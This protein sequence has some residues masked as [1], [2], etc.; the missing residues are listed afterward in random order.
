MSH[1]LSLSKLTGK[2]A[3][4]PAQPL[5]SFRYNPGDEDI[6]E[7]HSNGQKRVPSREASLERPSKAAEDKLDTT[8]ASTTRSHLEKHTA[9]ISREQASAESKR[10]SSDVVPAEAENSKVEA[11][12][13]KDY[14]S[15][16]G[17]KSASI[18]SAPPQAGIPV[19]N[20]VT[21]DSWFTGLRERLTKRIEGKIQNTKIRRDDESSSR[22]KEEDGRQASDDEK[23]S[24][25]ITPVDDCQEVVE[26]TIPMP[27]EATIVTYSRRHT[28]PRSESPLRTPQASLADEAGGLTGG[29]QDPELN[30]W[31]F[32]EQPERPRSLPAKSKES[33]GESSKAP[34]VPPPSPFVQ[35]KEY[36]QSN[37]ARVAMAFVVLA[38]AMPLP[39]FISGF[40]MGIVLSALGFSFAW[41]LLVPTEPKVPFVVPDYK[42]MPPLRVPK[43][44]SCVGDT[45]R[46]DTATYEG[47]MCQLPFS[48]EYNV[49]THHMNNTQSVNLVL[50][51]SILRLRWPKNGVPRRAMW[52][53][54]RPDPIFIDHRHYNISSAKLMLLP[55]K[56]S[57]QR[58]WNRKYPI[59]LVIPSEEHLEEQGKELATFT[60]PS[61]NG[62]EEQQQKAQSNHTVLY[63]FA[64]TCRS[65]EE[66]FHRFRHAITSTSLSKAKKAQFGDAIPTSISFEVYMS[67]LMMRHGEEPPKS[68]KGSSA[69]FTAGHAAHGTQSSSSIRPSPQLV[70][71]P[72]SY[73]SDTQWIN[74]L[75]GR[76]FHDFLTHREWADVVRERIQK[77]L[78]KIKVPFFM[79]ELMVTDINLGTELPYI[80]RTSEAVSDERGV[81][82]DLDLTYSGAFS[83][84]LTTKL[85][86]MRLKRSQAEEMQSIN[87]ENT[88][89]DSAVSSDEDEG[90]VDRA[91]SSAI[92]KDPSSASAG[93][94]KKI[95]D[96]VD[97]IAQSKYFQQATENRYIKRKME[98][99]SNTP[100]V[101]TVEVAYLI[102]TL[103]L[104]VPPP[105]TDRVWYGF[106]TL[107]KMQL[108]AKPKLGE[109]EVTIARVTERIEK[110]L[111]LEFQRI[112]VMP[113]MD[114]FVLPIMHSDV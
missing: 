89:E 55:E 42:H 45:V 91:E 53:E 24:R 99:M 96:L 21:T 41:Y 40:V 52:N 85:N 94:G 36:V 30:S 80:R 22:Q 78:A 70:S 104:N 56:L 87:H 37:I 5:M 35:A 26:G 23:P 58:I 13:V 47:W 46:S 77:K 10:K 111:F 71:S 82:V 73:Q 69:R 31:E 106:R 60:S 109:K 88:D 48:L 84:T 72:P 16:F 17:K 67:A 59:C 25:S 114:D 6:E 19:A 65:K 102:G 90:N 103:A 113:N 11:S 32:V 50:C 3:P 20:E 1:R 18:E 108:V 100:L 61:S 33:T 4:Q 107:P 63:L 39:S 38:V 74:V 101:L 81:W 28:P 44:M 95:L 112:L 14:L 27:S 2:P 29:A 98:E 34:A 79:E 54:K 51:G 68:P 93:T 49:E 83:M 97:K 57:K 7:L 43:G 15:K 86:L 62:T 75:L 110:M 76:M 66:W 12:P 9:D 92:S 64:R 8:S 105:P